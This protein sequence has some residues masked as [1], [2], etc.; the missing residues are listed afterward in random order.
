MELVV[1]YILGMLHYAIMHLSL[2]LCLV[3][4]VDVSMGWS[5]TTIPYLYITYLLPTTC[6]SNDFNFN[7]ISS[8][9]ESPY[10]SF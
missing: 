2:F 7:R 8:L 6:S 5:F 3:D 9:S 1:F 10:R 4:I